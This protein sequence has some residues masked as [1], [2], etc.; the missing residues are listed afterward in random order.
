MGCQATVLHVDDDEECSWLVRSSFE[1]AASQL[2]VVSRSDATTALTTLAVEPIDVVV[3]DSVELPDGT[4]FVETVRNQYPS[5]PIVLYTGK[6][7][8]DVAPSAVRAGVTEYVQKGTEPSVTGLVDRVS[9]LID[10]RPPADDAARGDR[11]TSRVDAVT[12]ASDDVPDGEEWTEL[13]RCDPTSTEDLLVTLVEAL[14]DRADE[15]PLVE[16]F[17]PEVLASLFDS[18]TASTALQVRLRV[19]AYEFGITRDGVVAVRPVAPD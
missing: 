8:D 13:A 18:T 4:P 5:L 11:L 1:R 2:R 15:R 10:D 17:D 7:R 6:A 16:T 9:Q 12:G 3:S 14:G 19:D